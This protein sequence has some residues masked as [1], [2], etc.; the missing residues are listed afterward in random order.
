MNK[1][2]YIEKIEKNLKDNTCHS[3]DLIKSLNLSKMSLEQLK[4]IS[5]LGT[6]IQIKKEVNLWISAN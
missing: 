6:M 2:W 5:F 4:A 1:K 3:N